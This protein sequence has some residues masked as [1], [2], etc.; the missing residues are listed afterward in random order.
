[1][2]A[3]AVAAI[4]NEGIRGRGAT[5]ET[6]E[7]TPDDVLAWFATAIGAESEADDTPARPF[8]VAVGA[9]GALLGW[10]RASS[11]RARSA[12]RTHA[13]YSVYVL[14]AAQGRRIGDALMAAFVPA[15]AAAGITKL[16]SRIF[17]EN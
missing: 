16:V 9:D 5:F 7:R 11:Y 4:Y 2:D 15:C 1:A 8:L 13:E 3:A 14:G 12:Y 17:P 6:R 10:V